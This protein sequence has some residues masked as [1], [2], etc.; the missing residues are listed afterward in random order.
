MY[1]TGQSFSGLPKSRT[2]LVTDPCADTICV[3]TNKLLN[4]IR[5]DHPSSLYTSINRYTKSRPICKPEANEDHPIV[6]TGSCSPAPRWQD[7]EVRSYRNKTHP[8]AATCSHSVSI[9]S[10][11]NIH[12]SAEMLGDSSARRLVANLPANKMS[13]FSIDHILNRAGENRRKNSVCEPS[14]GLL[15]YTRSLLLQS[16]PCVSP[17]ASIAL[18]WLQYSRYHPPKLQR[19]HRT[20][21]AKRTPGRLPRVPFTPEQLSTLEEAYRRST[22]LSSEDANKLADRLDLSNVR[23][24]IWFQNRR[25]RER[26]ERREVQI[27]DNCSSEGDDSRDRAVDVETIEESDNTSSSSV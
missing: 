21:P 2:A 23:V 20:G 1:I 22:Y 5:A 12:S 6:V 4:Q 26:R 18:G 25:A 17:N 13:D 7:D 27:R 11:S 3:S 24:K 8:N 16:P 10:S 19:Q 15:D 14:K 9:P